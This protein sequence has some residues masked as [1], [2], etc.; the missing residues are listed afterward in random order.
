[1]STG[2]FRK[3]FP[4]GEML[5][6]SSGRGC[7][8]LALDLLELAKDDEVLIPAYVPEG[9]LK[10]LMKKRIGYKFYDINL[11]FSVN[12]SNLEKFV[13]KNTKVII[14]IHYFGF[15]QPIEEIKRFCLER[16]IFLIEDCAQAFMS[17]YPDGGFVGKYGD[18]SL[19]S[20]TKTFKIPDGAGLLV[21]NP[22][23]K[24]KLAK[25]EIN[26]G[27]FISR[28]Y[29]LLRIIGNMDFNY[30]IFP[31]IR[32]LSTKISYKILNNYLVAPI[33]ISSRSMDLL[34]NQEFDKLK[35]MRIKSFKLYLDNL[36]YLH[37]PLNTIDNKI[38]PFGFP[39]L[40]DDRDIIYSELKK[41]GTYCLKN[42]GW[43]FIGETE[44]N[45][46]PNSWRIINE[47][48]TLPVN[49]YTHENEIM[50]S[51]NLLN[52]NLKKD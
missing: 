26:K 36:K 31:K 48:L 23:L 19:Y 50:K 47:I 16:D 29:V 52:Q 8:S 38:C 14:I 25:V 7:L 37:I 12:V 44:S 32:A 27:N 33:S 2:L 20:F 24:K 34:S 13:D 41:N 5:Y 46:F 21:N 45:K 9:I 18:M 30:S 6:M 10:P 11:D 43:T 49:Q 40:I 3:Y 17:Q 28:I 1:M 51:I 22:N 35:E 39:L 4:P 15:I 42:K